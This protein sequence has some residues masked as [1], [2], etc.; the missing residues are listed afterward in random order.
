MK[1]TSRSAL[2]QNLGRFLRDKRI[3]SGFTQ[4]EI[5]GRLGY[6]SPQFIS[7][8]ERGLC[9]PPLKNLRTLVKLYK[10]DAHELIRLILDE[11]RQVLSS[12]LLGAKR[13]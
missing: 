5:A 1:L 2:H 7:N 12:A 9:S 13:R 11:Q 4:A 10:M 6:S 8:F 3:S